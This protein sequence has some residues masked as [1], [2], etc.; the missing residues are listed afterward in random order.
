ML[1]SLI[2]FYAK[3]ST[4]NQV[5]LPP[6]S[7]PGRKSLVFKDMLEIL[8]YSVAC[9]AVIVGVVKLSRYVF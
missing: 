7:A 9:I 1:I 2:W 4:L 6:T 8:Y 5:G 3:R